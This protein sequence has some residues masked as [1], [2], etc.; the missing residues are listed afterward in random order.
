M[1]N[2][3]TSE[4]QSIFVF[5]IDPTAR[6]AVDSTKELT[7]AA[8]CVAGYPLVL[9]AATGKLNTTSAATGNDVFYG[10]SSSN[11]N[12]FVGRVSLENWTAARANAE[13]AGRYTVKPSVF[14]DSTQAEVTAYPFCAANGAAAT[15]S[16]SDVGKAVSAALV[17]VNNAADAFNGHTML[18]LTVATS[19]FTGCVNI[20][21]V[22]AVRGTAGTKVEVEIWL[23]GNSVGTAFSTV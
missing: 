23:N 20:G 14:L 12:E 6:L 4:N 10:I 5:G 2:A 19:G 16:T 13:M 18:K 9:V 15:I 3:Y 22:V 8:E 1:A 7:V 11:I 17:T 21:R